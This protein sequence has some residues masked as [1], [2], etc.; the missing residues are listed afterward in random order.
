MAYN[1]KTGKKEELRSPITTAL[2]KQK[3]VPGAT[4]APKFKPIPRVLPK[5]LRNKYAA[6]KQ[7]RA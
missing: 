6:K 5:K 4:S 2:K 7:S 3:A 1:L